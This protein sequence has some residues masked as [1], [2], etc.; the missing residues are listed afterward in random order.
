MK[1]QF[2]NWSENLKNST[3]GIYHPTNDAQITKLI[4]HAKK[5][6]KRVR[7]IG[8]SH[9]VSPVI[10]DNDECNLTLVT[11]D[12]YQLKPNDITIEDKLEQVTVNAGWKLGQLYDALET[13]D[14]FLQTQ[15]AGSAFSIGGIVSTPVHGARLGH[16]LVAD[17]VVRITFI[18]QD[19]L[20]V[21][22]DAKTNHDDF[23]LYRLGLGTFGVITSVTFQ[24]HKCINMSTKIA[25]FYNVFND[26]TMEFAEK[27][28]SVDSFFRTTIL[29]CLEH[30]KTESI[31]AE[32]VQCFIDYWNN[33]LLTMEW[34]DDR[35]NNAQAIVTPDVLQVEKVNALE[36]FL[37]D[38]NK[39][40]REKENE[41]KLLNTIARFSIQQSVESNMVEDRDMFWVS[42]ATRSYFMAYFIPVYEQGKFALDNLYKALTFIK[43]LSRKFLEEKRS[44]NIDLPSDLR[45]VTSTNKTKL[46]PIY[47]DDS[48]THIVYAG[49]E[50]VCNAYNIHLSSENVSC[51]CL[52]CLSCFCCCGFDREKLNQDFREFFALVEENW[53]LLGGKI[54]WGKM[55]GFGHSSSPFE[56]NKINSILSPKQKSNI[57]E[58]VQPIFCNRFTDCMIGI[59]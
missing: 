26:R 35:D 40:Y 5:S 44:F 3:T 30:A 53:T 4:L 18:D 59:Q 8:S 14:Y 16:G 12:R 15:T 39:R 47:C 57:R 32:Y 21:T 29:K 1:K 49:L 46:S 43:K 58:I 13:T 48:K 28:E 41:L 23:S 22:K 38:I 7:V 25:T 52:S 37:R 10:S 36:I 31:P 17:S 55:F 45:F 34:K 54:H 11:L 6:N 2:Q 50:L 24:L 56:S 19:G 9:S 27:N 51:G 20:V 33:S 42:Q